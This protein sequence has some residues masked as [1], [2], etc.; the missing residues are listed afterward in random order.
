MR[1]Q[2]NQ[3]LER[4][5]SRLDTVHF[6]SETVAIC[7]FG[8]GSEDPMFRD[9]S[10]TAN[11]IL[12]F[13]RASVEIRRLGG[14]T[15]VSNPTRVGFFNAGEGYARSPISRQGARADWVWIRPDVL[16]EIVAR[17]DPAIEERPGRPF[18]FAWAPVDPRLYL[19]LR[20]AIMDA[21]GGS[22]D[23]MAMEERILGIVGRAVSDA[24]AFRGKARPAR[25]PGDRKRQIAL[26]EAAVAILSRRIGG[27]TTLTGLARELAVSPFHLSR[28][29][30]RHTGRT[31]CAYRGRL[32][33]HLSLERL[34]DPQT[35]LSTLA[36]DLGF[37][38]HSH[39][40]L[41]FRTAFGTTPSAFRVSGSRGARRA[42]ALRRR[43]IG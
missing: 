32:R 20:R 6:R 22:A 15:Y 24:Y 31:I 2:D 10:P 37:S 9:P 42:R 11:A 17:H 35:D 26:V 40:T 29:F 38:S 5:L 41:A 36:Q 3:A 13:P 23:P 30:A 43:A 8:C 28:T 25:S 34:R 19:E 1:G 33:L 4:S 39:F 7:G 16:A 21:A 12:V 27:A 18:R 14:E